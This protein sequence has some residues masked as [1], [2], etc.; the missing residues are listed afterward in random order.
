MT[1]V[2]EI[3]DRW[4]G[5]CRKPPAVPALQAAIGIPSEPI[6][7]G[8]PDGGAGGS[9][10]IRRGIGATWSGMK[11]LLRNP[12]LLWF[13]LLF[14]LIL[15]WHFIAQGVV[16]DVNRLLL[17]SITIDYG[18]DLTGQLI[19]AT[20]TQLTLIFTVEALTV[21]CLAFSLAGLILSISVKKGDPVSF[22]HGLTEAKK[23]LRPLTIW[24]V[25]V[26]F[27]GTLP[28]IVCQYSNILNV[29]WP[30]SFPLM[31]TF[32]WTVGEFVFSVNYNLP[33]YYIFNHLEDYV[34]Y[35][36]GAVWWWRWGGTGTLTQTLMLSAINVF[37]FVLTLFV[38]PL[39]VLERR[40]LK[41]AVV[42]SFTL[43]RRAWGEVAVC[44]LSLGILV[45]GAAYTYPLF[46]VAAGIV[47]HPLIWY[48]DEG[49]A[50]GLLYILVLFSFAV[51]VA[52]IGG[53]ATRSLYTF[54]KTGHMPESDGM[55]SDT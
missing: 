8:R 36:G 4:L 11:T 38:V 16:A 54:A 50:A 2:S 53:I 48:R 26:A 14:G 32:H 1:R 5:L 22:I 46:Q 19:P 29:R 17:G 33:F 7:E 25:V 24:S 34:P 39:I 40:N 30:Q 12:Q 18:Q 20:L 45:Y 43:M 15:A 13:S 42:R 31:S 55:E 28:F 37:L 41:E 52:T 23:S 49:I 3:A 27:A 10:A 35:L 47:T 44:V 6:C 51:I 21:F 9:K